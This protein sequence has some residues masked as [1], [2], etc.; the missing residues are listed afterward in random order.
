MGWFGFGKSKEEDDDVEEY[1]RICQGCGKKE[2]EALENDEPKFKKLK[3]QTSDGLY[4][5]LFCKKCYR[6]MKKGKLPPLIAQM[7]SQKRRR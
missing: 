2:E 4:E 6:M 7:Q 3:Q 1:V 5:F